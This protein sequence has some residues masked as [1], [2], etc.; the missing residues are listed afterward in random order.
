MVLW[1][2][3]LPVDGSEHGYKYW[4]AFV[5]RGECVLRYDNELGKGDHRHSG[6]REDPYGFVD[7]EKLVADFL[8]DVKGWIDE[9]GKA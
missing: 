6:G 2:V 9:D 4:L 1:S 5:V 8:G 7:V 3:P